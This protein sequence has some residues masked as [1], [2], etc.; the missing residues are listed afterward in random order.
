MACAVLVDMCCSLFPNN[1]K[2]QQGYS[3]L[4]SLLLPVS[5][6]DLWAPLFFLYHVLQI[7]PRGG[8]DLL[9]GRDQRL[10]QEP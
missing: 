3:Q 9:T 2:N 1:E 6:L 4:I 10:S 8:E 7:W 5:I